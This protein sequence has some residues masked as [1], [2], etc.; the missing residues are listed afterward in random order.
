MINCSWFLFFAFVLECFSFPDVRSSVA[1]SKAS[2]TWTPDSVSKWLK[3]RWKVPESDWFGHSSDRKLFSWGLALVPSQLCSTRACRCSHRR[4][5]MVTAAG[6][7][8]GK[9]LWC[10]FVMLPKMMRH[11][12]PVGLGPGSLSSSTRTPAL[13]LRSRSL[14]DCASSGLLYPSDIFVFCHTL[15]DVHGGCGHWPRWIAGQ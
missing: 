14:A 6:V 7:T 13:P 8:S 2:K 11:S 15:L 5:P 1:S 9:A 12:L 10:C 3:G 4:P